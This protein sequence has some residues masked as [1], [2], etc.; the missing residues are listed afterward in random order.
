MCIRVN[1]LRFGP[2]QRRNKIGAVLNGGVIFWVVFGGQKRGS[3]LGSFL[4]FFIDFYR[5]F[6]LLIKVKR[7]TLSSHSIFDVIKCIKLP[8][9]RQGV[10]FLSPSKQS[11]HRKHTRS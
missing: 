9:P 1:Q 5:F 4:V 2:V 11:I 3:F 6:C 7:S 10:L 8:G